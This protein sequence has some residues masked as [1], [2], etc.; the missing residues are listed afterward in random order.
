M[1]VSRIIKAVE[2]DRGEVMW[3][4][5]SLTSKSKRAGA[6]QGVNEPKRRRT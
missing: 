6:T 5:R 2:I 3:R 4:S 1:L